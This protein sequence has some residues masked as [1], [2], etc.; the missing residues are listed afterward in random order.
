[1][2]QKNLICNWC[3]S[4]WS[5]R[6]ERAGHFGTV[7]FYMLRCAQRKYSCLKMQSFHLGHKVDRN[8]NK[9]QPGETHAYLVME[10]FQ[11]KELQK[12]LRNC[13]M[14]LIDAQGL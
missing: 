13:T 6:V 2:K 14:F 10:F 12:R 8:G 3:L 4:K 9:N 11:T 1:M 5:Q 7:T